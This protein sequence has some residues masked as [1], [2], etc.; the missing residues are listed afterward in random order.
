M[1]NKDIL[2]RKITAID[3]AIR[4]IEMDSR[5]TIEK[6]ERKKKEYEFMYYL[7]YGKFPG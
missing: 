4:F 7:R 3:T 6:L 2:Q 5:R 1:S